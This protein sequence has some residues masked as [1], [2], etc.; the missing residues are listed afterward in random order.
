MGE[1]EETAGRAIILDVVEQMDVLR[2]IST[3]KLLAFSMTTLAR[4][5]AAKSDVVTFVAEQVTCVVVCELKFDSVDEMPVG[6]SLRNTSNSSTPA[7]A[8][9]RNNANLL[10][11]KCWVSLFVFRPFGLMKS[12]YVF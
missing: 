9:I 3:M 12:C 5:L 6:A 2:Q 11:L 10:I 1:L 8:P 7:T 4:I